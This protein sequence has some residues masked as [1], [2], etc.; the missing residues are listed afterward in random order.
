MRKDNQILL[1]SDGVYSC[2][3]G[4]TLISLLA[5]GNLSTTMSVWVILMNMHRQLLCDFNKNFI[6]TDRILSKENSIK[7]K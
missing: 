1:C 4:N 6:M 2:Y 5:K 3:R 7:E